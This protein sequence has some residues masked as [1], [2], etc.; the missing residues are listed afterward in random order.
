MCNK[1]K[2]HF[3][4]RQENGQRMSLPAKYIK[5]MKTI[6]RK[7]ELKSTGYYYYVYEMIIYY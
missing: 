4:K 5:R 1:N 3:W 2:F 6:R 7:D